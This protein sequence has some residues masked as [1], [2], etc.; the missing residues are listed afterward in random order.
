VGKKGIQR[1]RSKQR[2]KEAV[3]GRGEEHRSMEKKR[4]HTKRGKQT[5]R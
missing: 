3:K 2:D 5:E 1:E 4:K